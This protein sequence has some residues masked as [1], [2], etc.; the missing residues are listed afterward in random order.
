[1]D[2]RNRSELRPAE[3]RPFD[4]RGAVKMYHRNLPHWRQDGCTYFVTFRLVDSIPDGV[5]R[6]WEHEQKLWLAKHRIL[7]DGARGSWRGEFAKLP[8]EEQRLFERH[9]NRQVQ[10]CLDRGL[11]QCWFKRLQC[12]EVL[13]EQLFKADGH[14]WHLGDFVIMPNHVHLL[15]TP[16]VGHELEMILKA[17]KGKSAIE[18]NKLVQRSEALWQPESYDHIVRDLKQL[19]AYREYIA[20]NPG[21]AAL[22]LPDPAMYRPAWMDAWLRT[23]TQ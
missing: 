21:R 18:C 13:S 20:G 17:I 7:Y 16:I 5:R 14:R 3:F 2:L 19:A 1:M 12:I 22:K 10:A 23:K 4:E 15:A 8:V 11:G 6:E 9:F